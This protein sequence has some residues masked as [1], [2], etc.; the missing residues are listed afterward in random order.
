MH[1]LGLIM[2]VVFSRHPFPC[3]PVVPYSSSQPATPI[4]SCP[5]FPQSQL[6]FI[7]PSLFSLSL[8][9][10]VS[11]DYIFPHKVWS[12]LYPP[13]VLHVIPCAPCNM[14]KFVRTFCCHVSI[15][16]LSKK[17]LFPQAPCIGLYSWV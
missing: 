6:Q 12:S 14:S 15:L 13:S 9:T 2:L 17:T 4:S 10:S 11:V 1:F 3:V 8:F 7:S 5:L 16:F